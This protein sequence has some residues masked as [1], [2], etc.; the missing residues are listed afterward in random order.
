V[1]AGIGLDWA[2]QR[3]EIRLAVAGS[4]TVES[5]TAEQKPAAWHA[6][7]AQLR[8]RFPQGKIA[9]ALDQSRGALIY[10]LMNY[11]CL[12][13]YPIPPKTLARYR[14]AFATR[15]A[16]SDPN[17]AHLLCELG[18]TPVD[19]TRLTNRLTALRKRYFP[20]ARDGRGDLRPPAACEFLRAGP[21][22]EAGPPVRRVEWK[23][24]YDGHRRLAAPERVDLFR[25]ID[26][27]QPLTR[28]PARVEA[29]ALRVQ[30][31]AEQRS[32]VRAVITGLDSELEKLFAQHPDP[33]L[34][35]S[36]PGARQA[37]APRRVTAFGSDRSR[38]DS[39]QDLQKFSGV[40]PVTEPNGQKKWVHG[41]LAC[42]KFVR[43]TFHEFAAAPCKKSLWARAYYEPQRKLAADHHAAVRSLAY[44]GIRIVYRCWKDRAPY[45]EQVYLKSLQ[46]HRSP[47]WLDVISLSLQQA[48]A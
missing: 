33:N 42:P 38:Y 41:R 16:K 4:T 5:F 37:L 47:R 15:G 32:A 22:L 20:Q 23:E 44:Q 11:D 13:L 18:R 45:D 8:A 48:H 27:A 21:T 2:D 24:F 30:G 35:E 40:A 25:Q 1:V 3:P 29:S 31:L 17:D 36:P 26:Q 14:E 28:D 34:F 12:L 10:A 7:V 39:A 9:V 19:R 43:Q 46:R 6:W